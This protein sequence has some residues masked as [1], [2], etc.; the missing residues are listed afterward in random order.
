[1]HHETRHLGSPIDDA[2]AVHAY[3]AGTT[4]LPCR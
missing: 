2:K 1:M 4:M 3:T